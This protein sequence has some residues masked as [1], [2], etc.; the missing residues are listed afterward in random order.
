[1][2]DAPCRAV[3]K[4]PAGIFTT[5]DVSSGLL[6]MRVK[7]VEFGI[8][9]L[10][11]MSRAIS[12]FSESSGDDVGCGDTEDCGMEDCDALGEGVRDED[13]AG[14]VEVDEDGDIDIE[15][16]LDGEAGGET[17]IDTEEEADADG[18]IA[19]EEEGLA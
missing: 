6:G 16:D 12:T 9:M 2:R 7:T 8:W 18:E 10:G 13:G 19:R 15:G 17:D 14:I 1:M 5:A 11:P 4:E 3:R